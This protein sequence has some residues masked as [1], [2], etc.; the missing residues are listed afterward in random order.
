MNTRYK[1]KSKLCHFLDDRNSNVSFDELITSINECDSYQDLMASRLLLRNAVES[2]ADPECNPNK[3]ECITFLAGFGILTAGTLLLGICSFPTLL[4][5]AY[6]SGYVIFALNTLQSQ[7]IP[8][9]LTEIEDRITIISKQTH[10]FLQKD[11][12]MNASI[13]TRQHPVLPDQ[14]P[15]LEMSR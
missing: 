12:P 8:S 9:L 2:G 11:M 7:E 6:L 14:K 5:S 13:H 1:L 3:S 10:G 4:I 15:T